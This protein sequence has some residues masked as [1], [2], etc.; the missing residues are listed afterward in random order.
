MLDGENM[1]FSDM[2]MHH[3]ALDG[4][5]GHQ[6]GHVKSPVSVLFYSGTCYLCFWATGFASGV[7]N[8]PRTW[9]HSCESIQFC[10][11]CQRISG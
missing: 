2:N 6:D 1:F 7:G 10:T 5:S 11:L 4:S 3:S 8:L 9:A